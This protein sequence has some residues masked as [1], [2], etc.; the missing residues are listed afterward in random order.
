MNAELESGFQSHVA[1]ARQS[2]AVVESVKCGAVPRRS[3]ASIALLLLAACACGPRIAT[4]T[5]ANDA[6]PAFPVAWRAQGS[7]PADVS[8]LLQAPAGR[9]GFVRVK[10]GHLVRPDGSR[11]RIWGINVT[12]NGALPPT[13]SAP[14]VASGLAQRGINCVR[15]H[16]LDRVGALIPANHQDTRSLDPQ[17]LERLD[18]FVFELKQRGIY[19]DLNLNVYRTYKSGDGVRDAE[20]LGIGK[21]ATYFDERL[22]ELQREYAR[23]LLTHTNAWTGRAY[24]DEPAVAVVEFVNENSLVEAWVQN[25]LLGTQTNKPSGTWHDIPPSYAEALRRKFNDWL[26]KRVSPEVLSRIRAEAGVAVGAPVPR[27]RKEQFSKAGKERFQSEAAFYMEIESN[28]FRDMAK[29]LREEIGVRSL[30]IANSDHGHGMSGYPLTSSMAQLDI[31]DG[32][33]Y[34]QHPNYTSDK[35][36]GRRSGFTIVNTPMVD[37]PLRSAP[38]QLSRTAVAGKP[39]TVSE[40]NHPF[41]S[42]YACEGVPVLAA[43]AALQDWDG[44]F[45]YTLAHEDPPRIKDFALGHFDFANDPVK[46]S[47]LAA[48]ALIFLRGD[49]R[50]AQRTVTRTYSREQVLESLRL[51]WKESPYFTP[52]FPLALPLTHAVRVASFD[53]PPTSPMEAVAA[54]PIESD[55]RE[56]RWLAAGKGTGRMIVDTVRSQALVG[57]LTQPPAQSSNLRAE[58][59]TPFC[60]LTLS[61]LDNKPVTSSG[62]LL[63]TAT[64]RVANTGMVWNENRTTLETWGKAPARIE[65]VLGRALLIRLEPA[66]A[67]TAQPLDGA[68]EP[69]GQPRA[70]VRTA[71]GWSLDLG[72]PATPWHVITV[73]R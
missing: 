45:W 39:Y 31:V 38:V 15:F 5:S 2:A 53:G 19:T 13:N 21:G 4:R 48:G 24:R 35:K 28:F 36:S 50:P 27:L 44:I 72:N 33:V 8:F 22:I 9:D 66:Q 70:L 59:P 14:V 12:G 25:R 16:F 47:Q 41:P 23:Q 65:P 52:G 55:T 71:D 10:D 51:P 34:W 43:Y 26:P 63:L 7:S 69:M 54:N 46:M 64:A 40:V 18:R 58:I 49:V 29:F 62:K 68:G 56:L 37:D 20:L 42:E 67:L 73:K 60:A 17:A 32:H 3:Y 6:W 11:F 30:L 61:A 1:A 57:H